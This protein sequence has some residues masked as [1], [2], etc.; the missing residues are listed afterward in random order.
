MPIKQIPLQHQQPFID[1]ADQMLALNKQ[2]HEEKQS[3][4]AL[5][6]SEYHLE[7]I[8]RKLDKFYE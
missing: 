4:L 1:K 6:Q 7:K 2:F 8:S 5:L 3:V